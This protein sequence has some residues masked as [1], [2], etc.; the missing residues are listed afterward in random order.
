MPYYNKQLDYR[1]RITL[2]DDSH[3]SIY[4]KV[5][6]WSEN[7]EEF[8][9]MNYKGTKEYKLF[10][11]NPS[12]RYDCD[13]DFELIVDLW[14]LEY[15]KT[16]IESHEL[17]DYESIKEWFKNLS[18][19]VHSL[20]TTQTGP[21]GNRLVYMGKRTTDLMKQYHVFNKEEENNEG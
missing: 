2:S 14:Q 16:Y 12:Q 10:L 15:I 20:Y 17:N 6:K 1:E 7:K 11:Y 21:F 5:F 13:F 8:E 9:S 4:Q 18:S 19:E 3:I